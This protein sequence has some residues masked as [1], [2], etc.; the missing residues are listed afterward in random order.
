MLYIFYTF[1][2]F[3]LL[4]L[5]RLLLINTNTKYQIQLL[6]LKER[7]KQDLDMFTT[8][9]IVNTLMGRDNP[10]LI[11][12]WIDKTPEEFKYFLFKNKFHQEEIEKIL[13]KIYEDNK[14]L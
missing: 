13:K 8:E 14:I 11:V 1:I 10:P 2:I 3:L 12:I 5:I 4:F 7:Q 6:N 9:E